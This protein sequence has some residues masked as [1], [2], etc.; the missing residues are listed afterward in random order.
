MLGKIEN[1]FISKE[2]FIEQMT[3]E[4]Q[5]LQMGEYEL[6]RRSNIIMNRVEL[7]NTFYCMILEGH[8]LKYINEIVGQPDG[9]YI[10]EGQYWTF[11]LET[12]THNLMQFAKQ[13]NM[14]ISLATAKE[15]LKRAASGKCG[16]K[17]NFKFR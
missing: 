10:R 14:E 6:N 1:G 11:D 2:D 16:K 13:A 4:L 9:E 3:S 15:I 5:H 12:T 17:S 7:L 8:L